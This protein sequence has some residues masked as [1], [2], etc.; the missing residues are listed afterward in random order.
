MQQHTSFR[1]IASKIQIGPNFE[2]QPKRKNLCWK[3]L[4]S[5]W[6]RTDSIFFAAP[7]IAFFFFFFCCVVVM[8]NSL[9]WMCPI[10]PKS[11]CVDLWIALPKCAAVYLKWLWRLRAKRWN[12]VVWASAGDNEHIEHTARHTYISIRQSSALALAHTN[13]FIG[14]LIHFRLWNSLNLC[15]YSKST[16]DTRHRHT[17]TLLLNFK[18]KSKSNL[19]VNCHPAIYFHSNFIRF[20]QANHLL[21]SKRSLMNVNS[22]WI[23]FKRWK[24]FFSF[25]SFFLFS[26]LEIVANVQQEY[27]KL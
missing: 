13:H 23:C 24:S 15:I 18:S 2:I 1:W 5:Y 27:R 22:Q 9:R 26:M 20:G 8:P 11:I 14:R 25:L 6:L 3:F 10:C 21:H 4:R 19:I 7:Y 16:L 17:K 12:V